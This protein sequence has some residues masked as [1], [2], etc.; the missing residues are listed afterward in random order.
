MLKRGFPQHPVFP[1]GLCKGKVL[2]S[3]ITS[4][5]IVRSSREGATPYTPNF[6][7]SSLAFHWKVLVLWAILHHTTGEKSQQSFLLPL[8]TVPK[9]RQMVSFGSYP[10]KSCHHF[11]QS[12]NPSLYL[13]PVVINTEFRRVTD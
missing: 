9:P 10:K 8:V 6:I 3:S 1:G 7:K 4:I 5:P 13:T 2:N 11:T 12:H